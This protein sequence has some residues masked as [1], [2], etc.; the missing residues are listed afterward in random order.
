MEPDQTKQVGKIVVTSRAPFTARKTRAALRRA[1][2]PVRFIRSGFRSVFVVEAE[3]EPGEL[4]R[5][6]YQECGDLIGR[7]TA[8]L[9]E[10]ESKKD[11][12]KQ[13]AVEIGTT[14]IGANQSF[15]FRLFKRGLHS[16]EDDT[17]KIEREI[18]GAIYAALEQVH[19]K[20]PQ[21]DLSDPDVE[22]NAEVLGPN[23]LVGIFEEEWRAAA[24][25]DVKEGQGE[26]ETTGRKFA[27]A[28]VAATPWVLNE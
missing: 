21:V 16:L 15:A 1:L 12:I 20:K 4:A 9:A 27:T 11:E 22:V 6:V 3:G 25:E 17:P 8:I 18:G 13:A 19:G 23:T 24:T 26:G 7:G 28:S 10:V 2:F 5:Q 14:R